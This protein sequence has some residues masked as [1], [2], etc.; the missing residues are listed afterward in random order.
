M[1]SS[2]NILKG[3][4]DWLDISNLETTPVDLI[5]L[6]EFPRKSTRRLS[7]ETGISK[8]SILRILHDDLKLFLYKIQ[9]SQRQ[10]DENNSERETF[11][12]DISQRIE[13]DTELFFYQVHCSCQSLFCIAAVSQELILWQSTPRWFLSAAA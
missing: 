10:T 5:R 9:I 12:E 8:I 11:C 7:Q 3:K 13:N 2:L 1:L 4:I 6:E